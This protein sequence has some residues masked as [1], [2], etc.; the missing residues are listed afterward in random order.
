MT[1]AFSVD[2]GPGDEHRKPTETA[3]PA[4]RR[5]RPF[6]SKNNASSTPL[7]ETPLG[8]DSASPAGTG[9]KT[10]KRRTK[11][12]DLEDMAK[13]IQG[14]HMMLALMTGM[15]EMQVSDAEAKMLATAMA[16]VAREFDMAPNGKAT[17]VVMLIGTVAIIY[18]PRLAMLKAKMDKAKRERPVTVEGEKV[19]DGTT[20]AT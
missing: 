14:T 5:G 3:Q 12:V 6:G 10:R 7:G 17:A 9:P 19:S 15:T 16:D 11:P 2:G 4:R 1:E 8:P 20:T 13:K 18:L